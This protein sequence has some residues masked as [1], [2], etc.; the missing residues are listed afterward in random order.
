MGRNMKNLKQSKPK[1]EQKFR[2]PNVDSKHSF[3]QSVV[4]K[5]ESGLEKSKSKIGFVGD[6][7]AIYCTLQWYKP[8]VAAYCLR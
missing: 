5:L 6:A 7:I 2:V 8:F 1:S 4:L 3:I